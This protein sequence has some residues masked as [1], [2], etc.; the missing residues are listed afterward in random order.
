MMNTNEV[1]MLHGVLTT[2]AYP[3]VPNS[4]KPLIV[5][6]EGIPDD[7]FPGTLLGADLVAREREDGKFI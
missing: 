7:S 5:D 2:L 6:G 1:A 3:K 4:K